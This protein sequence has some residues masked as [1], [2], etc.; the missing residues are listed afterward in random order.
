[1]ACYTPNIAWRL[2]GELNRN[3]K[4]IYTFKYPESRLR[5]T[6]EEVKL[7]C[8][9]CDSCR[10]EYSKEWAIR[11][12]HEAAEYDDNC[13]I[14]LTFNDKNLNSSG[15]LV[16]S[17]F[18]KFMKRLRKFIDLYE[19]DYSALCYVK[20]PKKLSKL[21]VSVQQASRVRFTHCGEYGDNRGRPHHHACLFNFDFKDKYQVNTSNGLPVY[22][23]RT[24]H[25]LWSEKRTNYERAMRIS[26]DKDFEEYIGHRGWC[27]IGSV[28]FESAAYVA[29]YITKKAVGPKIVFGQPEYFSQSRRPG[30]GRAWIE[31]YHSDIY[32]YD[33]IGLE[34]NR[35]MKIPRYYDKVF[36]NIDNVQY[37]IVKEKRIIQ[38]KENKLDM[39]EEIY[40][41][42]THQVISKQV[43]NNLKRSYEENG[44]EQS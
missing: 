23:S 19:Y 29:R 9:K 31:R 22:N 17:D 30:I 1:M 10:L 2:I 6:F 37:G 28:T 40:K 18:Q 24:L 3:G 38:A 44:A 20:R 11:S 25:W 34:E 43:L 7:P 4:A 36:E 39:D 32:P 33:F 14:T 5:N 15:V 27:V 16:K 41:N 13:F 8:R 26:D 42:R 12:W 21:E 35:R